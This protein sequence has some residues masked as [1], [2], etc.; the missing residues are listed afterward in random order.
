MTS[1]K[2]DGSKHEALS[3]PNKLLLLS[4][5]ERGKDNVRTPEEM[6]SFGIILEA[7]R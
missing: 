6:Y 1:D 4:E 2:G 7:E 5:Q 3:L